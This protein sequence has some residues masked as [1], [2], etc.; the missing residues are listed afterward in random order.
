[1]TWTWCKSDLVSN[2]K[3]LNAF[4]KL[5]LWLWVFF[6]L[7]SVASLHLLLE[8]WSNTY[9]VQ[10]GNPDPTQTTHNVVFFCYI[11]VCLGN[12]WLFAIKKVL[13][14]ATSPWL[15]LHGYFWSNNEVSCSPYNSFFIIAS[16]IQNHNYS[17]HYLTWTAFLLQ[18]I[19]SSLFRE[20]RSCYD[21]PCT[22]HL[23]SSL[24]TEI[25]NLLLCPP[26]WMLA[27]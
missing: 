25:Y 24:W 18:A 27:E 2:G 5:L 4:P 21:G 16:Q 6:F 1:M 22:S 8:N 7:S 9:S 10:W 15:L 14:F 19:C 20:R 17:T 3:P 26:S 23:T 12:S 13:N 11:T